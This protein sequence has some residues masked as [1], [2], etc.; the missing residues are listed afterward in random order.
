M[1][2]KH[3]ALEEVTINNHIEGNG[4]NGVVETKEAMLVNS[5]AIQQLNSDKR[6]NISQW[7]AY[8]AAQD[9]HLLSILDMTLKFPDIGLQ[10]LKLKPDTN[11]TL[12]IDAADTRGSSQMLNLVTR[13]AGENS[14]NPSRNMN[15]IS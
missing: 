1:I 6:G 5:S 13:V 2:K 11:L 4:V 9:G 14:I 7:V 10:I 3:V 8:Y 15:V 12:M